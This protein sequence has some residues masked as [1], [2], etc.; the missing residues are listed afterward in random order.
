MREFSQN[1]D[2]P[3]QIFDLI[4]FIQPFLLI[5]LDGHSLLGA[6]VKT[7]SDQPISALAQLPIDLIIILLLLALHRYDQIE[8]LVL[9]TL[10]L[11]NHVFHLLHLQLVHKI[12]CDLVLHDVDHELGVHLLRSLVLLLQ[13]FLSA[14]GIRWRSVASHF[15]DDFAG[16]G[17][18]FFVGDYLLEK[19]VASAGDIAFSVNRFLVRIRLACGNHL[20]CHHNM[21]LSD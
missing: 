18:P 14:L 7:H 12:W 3:L 15:V 5:N 16:R 20:L 13:R 9:R 19:I 8:Q 2:L 1:V 10:F 6:D 4:G 11:L 17:I 21:V